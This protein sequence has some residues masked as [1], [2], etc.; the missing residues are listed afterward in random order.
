MTELAA[1][2]ARIAEG[3]VGRDLRI[4][5]PY[6]EKQVL[7]ADWTASGRAYGPLEQ[8]LLRDLAPYIANT[9]TETS[10]TGHA[11]TAAY[12]RAREI[13]KAH[14]HADAHDVLLATGTGCTGAINKLQRMLGL[15][16]PSNFIGTA[17]VAE[18]QRPLVLITH[19]E[20]HSNQTSWLE[21]EVD[22]EVIPADAEGLVDVSAIPAILARYADRPLKIASVT[23]CS[24]VTGLTTPYHEIAALLHAHGGLCFVDFACSAPYVPIDMHP[25][26]PAQ[27]LDAIFFSPHKFLGGPGSAGVLV[28][29]SRMYTAAVPDQPGGGTVTWTN[30]WHEHRY[31]EDIEVR[32]DGG[33]PGF[34]QLIRAALAVQLK[35]AMGV[36]EIARREREIVERALGRLSGRPDVVVLAGRHRQRLPV[37][38]FYVPG[39]HYNLVVRMLNDRFGV[40]ARGGCSCAGTYGHFLLNVDARHSHEIT[41]KIDAGDLSDKPGWVRLSFHPTTSDAELDAVCDAVLSIA[42]HG[43]AWSADYRPVAHLNDYEHVSGAAPV[44]ALLERWFAA[45]R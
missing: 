28:F 32:E 18:S 43:E 26:D 6:G 3:I 1:H 21:C 9:H 17:T 7:Y 2:F 42:E 19:M 23:A 8:R 40:Q 35:E 33:T 45:P 20:H 41:S 29:S 24:N 5:T 44:E 31:Y 34:L 25:E 12:K 37:V 14:V 11:M 39:L 38:S 27:R 22:L 10:F 13:I 15:R 4:Q 36:A 16:A 30:P